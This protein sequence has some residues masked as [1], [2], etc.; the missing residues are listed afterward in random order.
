MR[1]Y[2]HRD[3]LVEVE[4]LDD[5]VAVKVGVDDRGEAV[6]RG[7][8]LGTSA[9]AALREADIDDEAADAFARAHWVFVKP[10]QQTRET[11][12][13]G[14]QPAGTESV[15]KV[16]RRSN[17]RI[18]IATDL[19]NVQLDPSL[20]QAEAERELEAAGLDVVTR[21]NF[22]KN[23]Y[24]VRAAGAEDALAASEDLHE[25]RSFVFAEPSFIEHVPQR[26]AP[27]DPRYPDQ[28]QWNNTG[29]GGGT[30]GADVDIERAWDRT[31]G[32][33]IQVAVIDNGFDA[34]H[35]DLAA[36]VGSTSGF[37]S[38]GVVGTTFTQSIVGMPDSNHGT[39]CAGMVGARRDN[40]VGGVGAAPDCELMLVAC[41]G[42]TVG[43]QTTLAR[44]VAY[45]ANP[46]TEVPGADPADGADILVCSLGPNDADWDLTSTLELAIEDAAA[47]GR[48]GRG[49]AIFWAASNGH[50]VSVT[51]DEVVS[52]PDVIAVVRSTRHDLEDNA[53]RGPEVELIAPGVDVLST[54]SGDVYGT[55]TG[56]SFAAPCAAGCAALALSMNPALTRDKLRDVMRNSAD[57]IGGVVYDAAGHNDDYGFGRVN[58]FEAVAVAA[59]HP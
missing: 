41:L 13:A 54:R 37:Y 52:H 4:Q 35:Q 20:S 22:A 38:D 1:H 12:A 16:I 9:R 46:A 58:A 34:Q 14:E 57:R 31:T 3:R 59:G 7:S 24:E 19:L 49:L 26:S 39:F 55:S 23:L 6:T 5:V 29:A 15:G 11:V 30:A 21:L 47:N 48:Q 33:G 50:N 56:T 10:S 43:T 18:G 2:Y 32:T 51:K 42:D 45:A 36:G 44:G 28:W 25:N 40:G 8:V 53:A 17:G 27:T